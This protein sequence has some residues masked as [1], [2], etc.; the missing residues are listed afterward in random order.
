MPGISYVHTRRRSED[1][2]S[3]AS[4]LF[5]TKENHGQDIVF[6]TVENV[7]AGYYF[8]IKLDVDPP[9]D[10]RLVLEIV[11]T[12]ETAPERHD[13]SLKLLPKFPFGELVIGLTG[14]DAGLG[15]W[16]PIAWRLSVLDGQGKVLAS[17][18]SFLWGTRIDLETK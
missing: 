2:V 10:G 8:Y 15:R 14:K 9:R 12:E 1:D 13:F 6:R 7:R 4:E 18:H 11:R 16:T 17:E 5:S 3:R